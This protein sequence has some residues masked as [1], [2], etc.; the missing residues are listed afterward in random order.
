MDTLSPRERGRLMRQVRGKDTAPELVVRRLLH[1]LGYRFR[2]HRADLP[3]HPDIVLSR[4]RKIIFVHGCFWHRHPRCRKTTTPATNREF[5]MSKFRHNVER[6]KRKT[7]QL[8]L[9]G[10][11][12]L[13]VWECE[14]RDL[15]RLKE[16]LVWEME[17]T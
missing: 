3:G 17:K 4:R 10:W 1:S 9:L 13:V 16:R 12:V 8:Q 6:D 5:W 11:E 2:L 14:T 15:E 7:C